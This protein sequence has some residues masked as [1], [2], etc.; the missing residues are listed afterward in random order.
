M[1]RLE[2]RG[3]DGV[4]VGR[5]YNSI[6]LRGAPRA[7]LLRLP[8]VWSGGCVLGLQAR[9]PGGCGAVAIGVPV[10]TNLACRG[11]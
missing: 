9:G 1:R 10:L 7:R 6:D 8:S 3:V 11:V 5:E 2:L 4:P